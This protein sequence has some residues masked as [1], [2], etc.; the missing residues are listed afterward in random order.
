[1]SNEELIEIFGQG[2][3]LVDQMSKGK[4]QAFVNTLFEGINMLRFDPETHRV[5]GIESQDGEIMNLQTP[6]ATNTYLDNW[7]S[8]F[9]QEMV[10]TLKY[11]FFQA[12]R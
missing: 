9:E 10:L 11:Q 12:F 4:N 7:L 3:D 8:I 1:M 6:V 5:M 2:M